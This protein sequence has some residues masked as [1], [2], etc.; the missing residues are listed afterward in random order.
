MTVAGETAEK[1]ALPGR[2]EPGEGKRFGVRYGNRFC[3]PLSVRVFSGCWHCRRCRTR[4]VAGGY[5]GMALPAGAG[6]ERRPGASPEDRYRFIRFT[7]HPNAAMSGTGQ[8]HAVMASLDAGISGMN[9]RKA[10]AVQS[11]CPEPDEKAVAGIS[12]LRC[13]C[14][15][16]PAGNRRDGRS[17]RTGGKKQ[18]FCRWPGWRL[19]RHAGMSGCFPADNAGQNGYFL[20]PSM[21]KTR[22]SPVSLS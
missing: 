7:G 16:G 5:A 22:S 4:T 6:P 18:R 13:P 3:R 9:L 17:G 10:G 11:S 21:M 1:T 19:A 2:G 12:L 8:R 14:K 15:S 20:A